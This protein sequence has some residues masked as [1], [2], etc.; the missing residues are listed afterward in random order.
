MMLMATWSFTKIISADGIF[1]K[2]AA[3]SKGE[4]GLLRWLYCPERH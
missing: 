1:I 4:L 3:S 2:F